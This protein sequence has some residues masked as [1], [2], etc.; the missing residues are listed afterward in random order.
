[1]QKV[2]AH[3]CFLRHGYYQFVA[4]VNAALAQGWT[5]KEISVQHRFLRFVCYVVLTDT[6]PPAA[7]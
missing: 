1:M 7:N 6:A 2:I 4:E 5:I 3:S